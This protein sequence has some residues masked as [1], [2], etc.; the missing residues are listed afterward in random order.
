MPGFAAKPHGRQ[1]TEHG[2]STFSYNR[3]LV[4]V[5]VEFAC[6]LEIDFGEHLVIAVE[7]LSDIDNRN[8][9]IEQVNKVPTELPL[10][11]PRTR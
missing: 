5:L 8:G 2:S 6:F 7:A 11:F 4:E 1:C 9:V 10:D 3:P